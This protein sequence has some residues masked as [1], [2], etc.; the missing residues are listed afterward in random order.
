MAGDQPVQR[1]HERRALDVVCE[2]LA[3][4]AVD[5]AGPSVADTLL[6]GFTLH[7]GD[8]ITD[9]GGYLALIAARWAAE[10]ERPPLEVLRNVV[11]GRFVTVALAPRTVAHFRVERGAVE[12]LWI[13][14][15]ARHWLTWLGRGDLT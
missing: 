3:L 9:A 1:V 4:V 12:S 11:R 8:L 15:D 13:T 10:G 14:S 6:P 7:L 5:G 2:H